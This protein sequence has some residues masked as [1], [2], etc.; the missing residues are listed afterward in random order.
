MAPRVSVVITAHDRKDFLESAVMSVVEQEAERSDYEIIVVKNFKDSRIDK[1]LEDKAVTAIHTDEKS[2]GAKISRG[3][4]EASGDIITFLD[5][6]DLF[7]PDRINTLTNLFNDRSVV[8]HHS[9]ILTIDSNGK[10]YS[11]GLSENIPETTVV[12][13]DRISKYLPLIMKYKCDWY[14]STISCRASV[15]K[16]Y[17][18]LINQMD[19]SIDKTLFLVCLESGGKFVFDSKQITKYRVHQSLTTRVTDFKSLIKRREDFYRRSLKVMHSLSSSLKQPRSQ[20]AARI[21]I[22]HGSLLLS[23]FSDNTSEKISVPRSLSY[24]AMGLIKRL[25][26]VV[27]WSAGNIS[28]RAFPEFTRRRFYS[29]ITGEFKRLRV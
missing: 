16:E 25:K 24:L 4:E 22:I 1:F 29:K 3:I 8:Y 5:D 26:V 7:T 23:F 6:D 11:K 14:T 2:F 12:E 18:S 27:V 9:S 13:A 19:T 17:V 28:V 21:G 20:Y 15:M 10:E